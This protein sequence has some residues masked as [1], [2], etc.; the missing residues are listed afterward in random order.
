M[1]KSNMIEKIPD[2]MRENLDFL[3]QVHCPIKD[4]FSRAWE[5]F[6][7]QYNG[8]HKTQLR[9]VVPMGGCGADIY[10]NIST[11]EAREKFPLVVTDMGYQE[12]FTGNFLA[13]PEKLGWFGSVPRE[14]PAHPLFRDHALTDRRG[15]F[16]VFGAMPH[17]ILVNHRR[18]GGRP[19]P[20]RVSDLS[21]GEYTGSLGTG[22]AEDDITELLLLELWKEQG[23]AGIRGLARNIGF[24]GRPQDLASDAVA[25]REGCCVYFMSSFFAHA[26]PRRDHLEIIW[27]EDGAVLNPLYA[28]FKKPETDRENEVREACASFLF[29]SELGRSLADSWFVHVHPELSYGLPPEAKFRWVGW[30]YILEKP[31][32]SRVQEIEEIYYDERNRHN[33]DKKLA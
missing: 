5:E 14:D 16:H 32:V 30:D 6:A 2:S 3:A 24:T 9:G 17:V 1:K 10:C 15:L 4:R 11:V 22:F 29:S 8:G 13:S 18:L 7:A 23:E 27:P 19:V 26:V 33:R 28:L 20:R 21:S 25:N 12:F 31:V